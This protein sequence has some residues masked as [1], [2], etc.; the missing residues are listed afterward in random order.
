ML[1]ALINTQ[2]SSEKM[3]GKKKTSALFLN[4]K[5]ISFIKTI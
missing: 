5:L 1:A 3:R 2:R 4:M